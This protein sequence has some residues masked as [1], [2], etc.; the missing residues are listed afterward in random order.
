MAS[1]GA[2]VVQVDREAFAEKAMNGVA[3]MEKDGEWSEGLWAKIR[4]LGG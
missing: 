2:T 4:A 1:E 3:T